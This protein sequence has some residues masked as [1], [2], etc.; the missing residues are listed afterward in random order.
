MIKKLLRKT[1][2]FSIIATIIVAAIFIGSL[3]LSW[4]GTCGIV[5]LI[6]LCFGWEFSWAWATGIW[7]ALCLLSTTIGGSGKK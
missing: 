6:T 1:T 4:I 7:L 2:G 5:K 3:G